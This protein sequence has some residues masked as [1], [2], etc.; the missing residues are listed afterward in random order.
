MKTPKYCICPMSKNIVDAIIELNSDDFA[1]IPT[2][3]QI[4]YDGGYVNKWDTN[5]FVTY[6]KSK[7]N[8]L[9]GRDHAG[10]NQ[11][12]EYD[13][14]YESDTTDAM[15]LDIIHID[16]WKEY[17]IFK[18]GLTQTIEN[19]EYIYN[20]NPNIK[21]EIGTE[22]AI[23]KFDLREFVEFIEQLKSKL[24]LEQFN[25]IEYVCIQS[26]VG[27]DLV[28]QKNT[29]VFNLKKLQLMVDVC[30]QFGKK[31]KEHNGDYLS[32]DELKVRFDNGVDTLNIG[33]EIAQIE[34]LT[35]LEH[36]Y[37]TQ[38]NEFYD[39]CFKSEKWKRWIKS[40]FDF[41]NKKE[42]IKVC[43]HYCFDL[44]DLPKIDNIIKTNIKNK[45][46]NLPYVR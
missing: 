38:I 8:I 12:K 40:D 45:L 31:T 22:Q 28:N 32:Y 6:V 18:D 21:F 23:R 42:L 44:Y 9:I 39:I 13:N 27:I 5:S 11:G 43:G 37:D 19:I 20:I 17:P 29:G 10:P 16:S 3:R 46:K 35:Y 1:L 26:G 7:S 30:K 34:T 4:D 15:L 24:T 33:P 41:L 36:M 2:R 14:G 25:N